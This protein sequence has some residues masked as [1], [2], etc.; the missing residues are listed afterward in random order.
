MDSHSRTVV[1]SLSWRVVA[2][3]ITFI[4]AFILTGEFAMAAEIGLLDTFIKLFAYYFHE[5]GWNRVPYGRH[6]EP[7]YHI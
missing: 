3:A 6:R 7:E 4:V 1:K 2:T 5:R